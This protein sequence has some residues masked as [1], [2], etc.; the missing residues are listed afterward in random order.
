MI[1]RTERDLWKR[2]L[3]K[4]TRKRI[5]ILIIL[6]IW[7]KSCLDLEGEKFLIIRINNKETYLKGTKLEIISEEINNI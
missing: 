1:I 3:R 6:Q 2:E 7:G 5:K 4:F